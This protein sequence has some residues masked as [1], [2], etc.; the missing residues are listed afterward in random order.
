[1]QLC[2]K[3]FILFVISNIKGI[4]P[5]ASF[6]PKVL[7]LCKK[8][9]S[10]HSGWQFIGGNFVNKVTK[11]IHFFIRPNFAFKGGYTHFIVETGIKMPKV[12][13]MVDSVSHLNKTKGFK[14]GVLISEQLRDINLHSLTGGISFTFV[15]DKATSDELMEQ[16]MHRWIN[17]SERY[18]KNAWP[19]ESHSALFK[20][21]QQSSCC[22][23]GLYAKALLCL[24]ASLGKFD[25]IND[26]YE[27]KLSY[28]KEDIK[29]TE[30]DEN[31]LAV[32]PDWQKQWETTGKIKV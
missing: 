28:I 20:V 5:M 11:D 14:M 2:L 26:Y 32:L 16:E 19:T 17:V 6:K 29:V 3:L 25:F 7:T 1:M 21:M 8:V 9:A 23:R 31:L 12:T 27:G 10:E 18:L 13:K 30:T 24:A 22:H 15:G 4:N